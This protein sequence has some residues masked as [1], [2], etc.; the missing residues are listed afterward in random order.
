[1]KQKRGKEEINI[2]EQEEEDG[3][4]RQRKE[5]ERK[6]REQRERKEEQRIRENQRIRGGKHN[7]YHKKIDILNQ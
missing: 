7:A 5:R 1:M 4:K 6:I 2:K 3:Y